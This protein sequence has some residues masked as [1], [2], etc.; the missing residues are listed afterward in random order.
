MD[1]LYHANNMLVELMALTKELLNQ[2]IAEK[3]KVFQGHLSERL[4]NVFSGRVFV[5]LWSFHHLIKYHL[6]ISTIYAMLKAQGVMATLAIVNWG[7]GSKAI[8]SVIIYSK[9]P[10]I[11]YLKAKMVSRQKPIP[12]NNPLIVMTSHESSEVEFKLRQ[13]FWLLSIKNI[14]KTMVKGKVTNTILS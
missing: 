2:A 14:L 9:L 11:K 6:L 1:G 7:S 8:L 13:S 12:S 5:S 3:A 10:S 4:Q